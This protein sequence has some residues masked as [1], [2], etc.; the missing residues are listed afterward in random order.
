MK[1]LM[2]IDLFYN[3]NELFYFIAYIVLCHA[4]PYE[5]KSLISIGIMESSGSSVHTKSGITA[6][7]GWTNDLLM[8]SY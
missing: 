2:T 4:I 3:C 8:S 6:M 7:P 5:I 1:G